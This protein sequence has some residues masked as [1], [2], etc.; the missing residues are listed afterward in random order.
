M[1]ARAPSPDKPVAAQ[2]FSVLAATKFCRQGK[3]DS[4]DFKFLQQDD[5]VLADELDANAGKRLTEVPQDRRGV[6]ADDVIRNAESDFAIEGR[7]TKGGDQLLVCGQELLDG[8]DQSLSLRGRRDP[9]TDAQ[10]QGMI[11]QFLEAAQLLTDRPLREVQLPGRERHA[12]GFD[13][14]H[15]RARDSD[16][17]IAVHWHPPMH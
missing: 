17:D 10:E 2:R 12:A 11:G 14:G 6:A 7:L 16:V 8:H 1:P 4:A 9:T 13:D 3:I 15:E 5:R